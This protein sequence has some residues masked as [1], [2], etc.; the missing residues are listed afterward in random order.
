MC[1]D[2]RQLNKVTMKTKYPLPMIDD[3]FHKLHGKATSKIYMRSVFHK[4]RVRGEDVPKTSFQTRCGHYI[5]LSDDL[6]LNCHLVIFLA[7]L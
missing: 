7:L 4:P 1:I 2:Y 6:V 5:V 3:L